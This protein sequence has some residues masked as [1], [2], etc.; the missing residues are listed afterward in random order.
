VTVMASIESV[1]LDAGA[2]PLKPAAKS[3]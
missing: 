2:T 1:T 3:F